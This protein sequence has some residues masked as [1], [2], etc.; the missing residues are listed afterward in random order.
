MILEIN[1]SDI[2]LKRR[3]FVQNSLRSVYL[4]KVHNILGQ[5]SPNLA[6][7]SINGAIGN[8]SSCC[9]PPYIYPPHVK[10]K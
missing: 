1:I 9:F 7:L 6:T 3:L 8:N 5:G 4:V 10:L 2:L